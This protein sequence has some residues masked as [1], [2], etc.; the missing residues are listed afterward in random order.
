MSNK[1]IYT[2]NLGNE[3]SIKQASQLENYQVKV[4]EN[5][6]LLWIESYSKDVLLGTSYNLSS[7]NEISSIL[8]LDSNASFQIT[9]QLGNYVSYECL[10]YQNSNLI[11]KQIF[12]E[13]HTSKEIICRH[14]YNAETNTIIHSNTIK[15]YYDQNGIEI[16]SFDYNED[17]T[18]FFI[19][20]TQEYQTDFYAKNI[21]V[22][23]DLDFTW[24]GFKYYQFSEPLIPA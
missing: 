21:G 5:D 12:L 6:I 7:K 1:H 13:H 9:T 14:F 18:C 19:N 24:Q 2:N 20:K 11:D 10:A 3:I 8:N 22:D 23:P 15:R 16:Y 17:G 4:Y